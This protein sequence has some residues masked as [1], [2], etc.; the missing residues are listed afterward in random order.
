M[1]KFVLR[2][3]ILLSLVLCMTN[4][5][6]GTTAEEPKVVAKQYWGTFIYTNNSSSYIVITENTFNRCNDEPVLAWTIGNRL[7]TSNSGDIGY[8]SDNDTLVLDRG[9]STS[10]YKRSKAE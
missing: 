2:S 10:T 9:S 6:N 1:K 8:F 4:C 7:H 5:D 3:L